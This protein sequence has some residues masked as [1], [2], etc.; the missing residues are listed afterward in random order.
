MPPEFL[1]AEWRYLLMLNYEVDPGML[2]PYLPAGVELDTWQGKHLLSVVGFLFL[3]TRV[4]GI[5]VPGHRNFEEVNL[6]FYVRR[7]VGEE[8]RRGVVFVKEIVPKPWIARIARWFYGEN[9]VSLPMQ[10]TIELDEKPDNPGLVEYQWRLKKRW[11][12]RPRLQRLGG[13][14]VGEP[15]LANAGSEEEFITEHYW[16]YTRLGKNRTGE[17][18]VSH[19]RW[20]LWQVEQPYLLSDIKTL[21]GRRFEDTLRRRPHSAFLAE[22]STV[23][24]KVRSVFRS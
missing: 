6:R 4:L 10:H 19:P 11:Y 1:T 3:K 20:R 15:F 5:P 13:L 9:Y 21:Y 7:Q 12:E 22:G 14:A 18:Q 16:G 23:S 2:G 8:W 24:V 17:Y